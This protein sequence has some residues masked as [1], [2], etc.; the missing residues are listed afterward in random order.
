MAKSRNDIC[1]V[2]HEDNTC[3]IQKVEESSS[4]SILTKSGMYPFDDMQ[5]FS[6]IAGSNLVYVA[7][8]VDRESRIEAK[9]L[10]NLRRSTAL[11][12]MM[13]FD[14]KDKMDIFKFLPWIVIA[15]LILF[16]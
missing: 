5:K 12:A 15:L 1:I 10:R 4:E 11:Q 14:V 13:R 7:G 9:N 3:E 6:N 2:F 16:K 8:T